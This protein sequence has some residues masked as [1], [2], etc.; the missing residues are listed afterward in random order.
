MST[1]PEMTRLID[2]R[3]HNRALRDDVQSGLGQQPKRL[4]PR[5]LYDE[6]G[7][8]LFDAITE[9]DEYYPTRR[10]HEILTT[11]ASDIAHLC[12]VETL[13]E[14]GSGASPKTR[15][16]LDALSGNDSLRSFIALDVAE[17]ALD[18]S[19]SSIAVDYP[20]LELSGIV[21]DFEQ[22]LDHLASSESKLVAFLGGTIGNLEPESRHQFLTELTGSMNSGDFFLVGTDLVK[23]RG[24][25]V[26]A[27]D[28]SSGVTAAF[29]L[30]VLSFLNYKLDEEYKRARRFETPLDRDATAQPHRT[31]R[32][33][34]GHG[35]AGA[36]RG[37]RARPD[38]GQHQ[39][40]TGTRHRRTPCPRIGLR[41]AMDRQ[42]G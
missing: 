35:D 6:Q 16:L 3:E 2:A 36:L 22:H 15:L 17:S 23:D 27:Y 10:E 30:N 38:R 21:G 20:A 9:L 33:P 34:S 19:L 26:A 14:L 18:A 29:N 40:R 39:V 4:P 1:E 12:Q 32:C 42:R 5:W 24:R 7:C 13:V 8:A 28:D 25:L 37:G 31:N 41:R 11:H